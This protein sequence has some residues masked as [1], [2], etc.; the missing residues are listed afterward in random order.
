LIASIGLHVQHS[1]LFV[2]SGVGSGR[3]PSPIG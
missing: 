2:T 3:Q 1:P